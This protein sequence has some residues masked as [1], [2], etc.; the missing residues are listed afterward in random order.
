[1]PLPP[2][3]DLAVFMGLVLA[4]ALFGLTASG[5]FPSEHRAPALRTALGGAI[6]WLSM[7]CAVVVLA[8]AVLLAVERL[9]LY[10]SVIGGGAMLLAAPLVL[11]GFPD[12][13]VDGRAGLV[14]FAGLGLFLVAAS[15]LLAT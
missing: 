3:A 4:F 15:R 12:T 9:P 6:L 8:A 7:A 5:H 2:L 11:Q 13:F 14:T 10:A 1:M